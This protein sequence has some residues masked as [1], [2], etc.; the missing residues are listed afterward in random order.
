MSQVRQVV[1][2]LMKYGPKYSTISRETGVSV[3]TVRYII[4][5]KLSRLGFTIHPAIN[6][7]KLGLRRYL[8]FLEPN[9][10]PD[11][12]VNLLDLFGETM[13]LSY[14]AYLLNEKKFLTIFST[15]SNFENSLINFLDEL[16]ILGV[17]RRY[18]I[19]KLEYRR[20]IPFRVDCFDF[21]KGV[22]LQNWEEKPRNEEVP[23]IYEAPDQLNGLTGLDL[24]ILVELF[25]DPFS[26]CID[27]AK[28]LGI[29]RQT[30]KRHLEK[31]LQTIYLYMLYWT[32]V[33]YPELVCTPMFLQTE[34]NHRETILNIPFTYLEMRDENS[35]Y[36]SI[37]LVP[38]IG[39]YKVL[40]YASERVTSKKVDFLS[41]EY[42]GNFTVAYM[43]FKDRKGWI[44]IFEEGLQKIIE[45]V[46]LSM[47]RL[48]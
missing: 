39:F 25:K 44:N 30:V 38:S 36:Y 17:F 37:S 14:Y 22:W 43:L 31:I 2:A 41:M 15:P 46:K 19:K 29:T 28:K 35:N 18:H 24:K 20:I 32:P 8:V 47:R 11:Y 5:E 33:E 12:L 26:S 45:R 4:R 27:L 42:A 7:G 40:R 48:S 13:Y 16:T 1:E 6:Y 10:S 21:E 3:T 23:E 34:I 9:Y